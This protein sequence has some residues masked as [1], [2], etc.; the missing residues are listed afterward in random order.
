MFQL[1]QKG[2]PKEKGSIHGEQFRNEIRELA[3]IR[4]ELLFKYLPNHTQKE[5]ENLC[6][7]HSHYMQKNTPD[8]WEEFKAIADSSKT[9]Q[10]DLMILN[11]YT[12]LRDFVESPKNESLD[13]GGCSCIY[14]QNAK[15]EIYGGQTWDM[16]AS[17][18]KF[19]LLMHDYDQHGNK[20]EIL[21]VTGC[22]ALAGINSQKLGV[23]IN[24]VHSKKAK[25]GLMW[26]AFVR[27]LL[28]HSSISSVEEQFKDTP[29]SS[30]HSYLIISP[31]GA[32]CFECTG[33]KHEKIYQSKNESEEY[34]FHTNHFLG[35]IAADEN[36]E[37]QSKTTHA[38][39]ASLENFF[40]KTP[41]KDWKMKEFMAEFLCGENCPKEIYIAPKANEPHGSSTCGG[42]FYPFSQNQPGVAYKGIYTT[43]QSLEIKPEKLL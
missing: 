11:N 36:I 4:K 8:L 41:W 17:A 34:F 31:E 1:T 6:E 9:S 43:S 7:A 24:N 2:S 12:D 18:E 39:Y 13:D 16:H 42:L 29:P 5:I 14:I 25:V 23:F 19:M 38:R 28:E 37:R 10:N 35:E 26:P 27:K 30:A 21:T 22:L 40:K 32:R 3:A 15:G 20:S 33:E